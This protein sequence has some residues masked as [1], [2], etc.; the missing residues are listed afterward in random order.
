MTDRE[1]KVQAERLF[2]QLGLV[3][4]LTLIKAMQQT[5]QDP[6]DTRFLAYRTRDVKPLEVA[7]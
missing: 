5:L 1:L 3:D 6:P 4:Y 2:A 7:A